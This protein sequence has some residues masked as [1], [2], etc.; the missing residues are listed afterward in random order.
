MPEITI[1]NPETTIVP[2]V[3]AVSEKE[4]NELYILDLAI[5]AH[6]SNADDTIFGVYCP[7]NK[8]TGERLLSDRREIRLPFWTT[9][10]AVPSAAA[11]FAAV[12]AAW[13]DLIAYQK[14]MGPAVWTP[15]PVAHVVIPTEPD[16]VI[17][18][19]VVLEV[20]PELIPGD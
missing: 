1:P 4:F 14:S 7:Y 3:P 2:P 12:A 6:S 16:P 19:E 20:L 15:S 17:I 9:V 5:R 10:A 8:T 18:P 13:P 11:A